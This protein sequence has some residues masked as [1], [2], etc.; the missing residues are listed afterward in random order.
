MSDSENIFKTVTSFA[1]FAVSNILC[2]VPLYWPSYL[3]TPFPCISLVRKTHPGM[4]KS[5][6]SFP[7]R[8]DS[9]LRWMIYYHEEKIR[10]NQK[11]RDDKG[12]NSCLKRIL[13]GGI[14]NSKGIKK[15]R[16]TC[17]HRIDIWHSATKP[18]NNV[19]CAFDPFSCT[20]EKKF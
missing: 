13:A 2:K 18:N 11:R 7:K 9:E 20:I 12:H 14:R 4:Q 1:L 6:I 17:T 8:L 5:S 10:H 3:K 16:E 15:K 19:L